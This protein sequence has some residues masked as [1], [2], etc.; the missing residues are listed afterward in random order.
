MLKLFI[1]LLKGAVLG[2][3]VGYGA[4]ALK[5]SGGMLWLTYGVVGALVGF[6]VGRPIWSLITDKNATSIVSILK[7]VVGF[8]IGCGLYAL[9]AK[10]WGGFA[11][12]LGQETRWVQD[13]QP[14]M[15][16][17]IGGLWGGFIELDDA[18]GGDK[19]PAKAAPKALSKPKK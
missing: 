18:I 12:T 15:G 11:L 2:G 7:A 9:V 6:V 1:G 17:A 10:V 13:W 16:A 5:L 19:A 14:V 3:A 8:G 4:Y